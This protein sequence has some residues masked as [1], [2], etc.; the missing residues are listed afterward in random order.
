MSSISTFTG[1]LLPLPPARRSVPAMQS[2]NVAVINRCS[3]GFSE[4][5]CV[6]LL[7]VS[8]FVWDSPGGILL[9]GQPALPRWHEARDGRVPFA[10]D[11][12]PAVDGLPLWR[13]A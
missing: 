2:I 9:A 5:R 4:P 7:A 3:R 6:R 12:L 8:R 1:R 13:L 10:N 11:A